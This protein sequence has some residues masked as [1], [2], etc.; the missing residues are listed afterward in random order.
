MEQSDPNV[1][2]IPSLVSV[3]FDK[4]VV[5]SCVFLLYNSR[6]R[7]ATGLES[8]DFLHATTDL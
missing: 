5:D 1:I 3:W 8:E 4:D 7:P 6:N 2:I